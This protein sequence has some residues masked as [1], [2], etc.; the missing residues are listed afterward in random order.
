[1]ATRTSITIH[2]LTLPDIGYNVWELRDLDG[3]LIDDCNNAGRLPWYS[4]ETEAFDD[5]V[6]VA[7]AKLNLI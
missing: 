2:I 4:T 3:K 5:A 1:M 6:V 7:K